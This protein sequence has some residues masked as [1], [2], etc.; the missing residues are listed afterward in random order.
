MGSF[1]RTAGGIAA[2]MLSGATLT[3]TPSAA[4]AQ[5]AAGV[6]I[7][8]KCDSSLLPGAVVQANMVGTAT[9]RLARNCTYTTNTTLSFTGAHI[10]LLGGPSTAIKAN[11]TAP[12]G[13]ILSVANT[14]GLRV[15]GIF[16]LGGNITG[17]GGAIRNDGT[18]VL[19]FTT[20]TGNAATGSGG[21]VANN[22][23]GA[24]ALIVHSIIKANTATNGGGLI[25]KGMLT[26]FES[27]VSGNNVTG[28]GGGVFTENGGKT[29]I[30]QSTIDKNTANQG[31]GVDNAATNAM[32]S[33]D[34]AL[35]QQNKANL[36]A[37]GNSGGGIFDEAA[38][39]G[40]VTITRSIVRRNT[41]NNCTPTIPGCLG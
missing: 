8:V 9:I 11:R 30:I 34:R 27:I 36:A 14:A 4:N 35:V 40:G 32:T 38:A 25:N 17:E 37:P 2:A 39:P 1:A 19:N 28:K 26:L 5:S 41:P 13:P 3:A 12:P 23:A 16:I 15:R 24:R 21:A 7:P 31:G 20:L 6:V 22:S 33:F 18:L 10:T 29:R